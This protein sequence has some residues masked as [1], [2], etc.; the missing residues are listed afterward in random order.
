QAPRPAATSSARAT[1]SS[2]S[3]RAGAARACDRGAIPS[4]RA[5]VVVHADRVPTVGA[6]DVV[7]A[8][9]RAGAGV[10][11]GR[12]EVAAAGAVHAHLVVGADVT[13]LAAVE[14]VV[15]Q[16]GLGEAGAVAVLLAEGAATGGLAH[17]VHALIGAGSAAGPAVVAAVLEVGAEAVAVGE[18]GPA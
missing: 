2:S 4:H 8:A 12:R 9:L 14:R 16:L 18:A 15:V 5:L 1:T 7:A 3:R 17:A 11:A 10:A 13:A 6:A